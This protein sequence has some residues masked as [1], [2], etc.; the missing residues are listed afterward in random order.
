[1]FY[2]FWTVPHY[3]QSSSTH[4]WITASTLSPLHPRLHTLCQEGGREA[5][6]VILVRSLLG[7]LLK[8]E[9]VKTK[10]KLDNTKNKLPPSAFF[11]QL[12]PFLSTKIINTTTSTILMHSFIH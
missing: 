4:A 5:C 1:M 2:Y 11:S 10:M 6:I 9:R 7:S 12:S 3:C 8:A